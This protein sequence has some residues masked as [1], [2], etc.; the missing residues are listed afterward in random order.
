M[1][2]RVAT[3][4][5]GSYPGDASEGVWPI[6]QQIGFIRAFRRADDTAGVITPIANVNAEFAAADAKKCDIT[7]GEFASFDVASLPAKCLVTLEI[8]M[9]T[10]TTEIFRV[11]NAGFTNAELLT[12]KAPGI[13]VHAIARFDRSPTPPRIAD[14][15]V[16]ALAASARANGGKLGFSIARG[17]SA[18]GQSTFGIMTEPRL[19]WTV[20]K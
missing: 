9:D 11:P 6:V 7:G 15:D 2:I 19:I 17:V 16:T 13:D 10:R 12:G 20:P 18:T 5:G 14:I 1:S 8:P 4:V 3:A